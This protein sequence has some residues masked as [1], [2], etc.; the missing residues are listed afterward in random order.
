MTIHSAEGITTDQVLVIYWD[1]AN[2]KIQEKT[3]YLRTA[4]SRGRF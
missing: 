4:L 2:S 1:D 3:C